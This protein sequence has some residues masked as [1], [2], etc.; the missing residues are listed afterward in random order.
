MVLACFC[1][2]S[3]RNGDEE[4]DEMWRTAERQKERESRHINRNQ[5]LFPDMPRVFT[6]RRMYLL[7][8]PTLNT[9]GT[10][11]AIS[12]SILQIKKSEGK[13]IEKNG[14][15]SEKGKTATPTPLD[16]SS[17]AGM[18]VIFETRTMKLP[19]V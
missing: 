17:E 18:E 8:V 12:T 10:Q 15:S 7:V 14:G 9:P 11:N 2:E 19:F 16:K 4:E 3:T 5:R 1:I 13:L 6:L